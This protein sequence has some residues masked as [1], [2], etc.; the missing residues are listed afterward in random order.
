MAPSEF[1]SS[2]IDEAVLCYKAKIDEWRF[3]RSNTYLVHCSL[4]ESK[5]RVNIEEVL[6]LPFDDEIEEA[7]K[8]AN[9]VWANQL[10]EEYNRIKEAGLLN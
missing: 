6:P 3:I 10:V 7:R 2:T 5:H 9:E 4:I 1:W 8:E